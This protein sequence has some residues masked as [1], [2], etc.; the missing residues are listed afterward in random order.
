MAS[1]LLV[2]VNDG[3]VDDGVVVVGGAVDGVVDGVVGGVVVDV[4]GEPP[5]NCPQ[6]A[7]ATDIAEVAIELA[8][9]A[10]SVK[11]F[12]TAHIET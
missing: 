2:V 11:Q 6:N 12:E 10:P 8:T 1:L 9:S 4:I 7:V 5:V 3:D